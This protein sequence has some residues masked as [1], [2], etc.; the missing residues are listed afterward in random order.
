MSAELEGIRDSLKR[1]A[2]T[3]YRAF[4]TAENVFNTEVE[5][6]LVRN[7]LTNADLD[8]L[9]RAM[10]E[11]SDQLAA[12][13]WTAE[14]NR[15]LS[16]EQ[17]VENYLIL[18]RDGLKKSLE[19]FLDP[20]FLMRVRIDRAGQAPIQTTFDQ[21]RL[22]SYFEFRA[23]FMLKK[24]RA[25]AAGKSL[26]G[27]RDEFNTMA[28][29]TT[30][31]LDIPALRAS[32]E[33]FRRAPG[34]E[35]LQVTRE[36]YENLTAEQAGRLLVASG[37]AWPGFNQQKL[38]M[39]YDQ[40]NTL[41][42]DP[43]EYMTDDARI[44]TEE[45]T[46]NFLRRLQKTLARNPEANADLIVL[47]DRIITLNENKDLD[48]Q[49]EAAFSAWRDAEM[50]AL[51]DVSHQMSRR[52]LRDFLSSY[53]SNVDDQDPKKWVLRP[54]TIP[55]DNTPQAQALRAEI[56]QVVNDLK[57]DRLPT[58]RNNIAN[59]GYDYL[60]ANQRS[61]L[62]NRQHR[63]ADELSA[64]VAE[65]AKA[66]TTV[67]EKNQESSADQEKKLEKLA[68]QEL[69]DLAKSLWQLLFKGDKTTENQSKSGINERYEAV[70]VELKSRGVVDGIDW[71][72]RGT[73]L[74]DRRELFNAG[75]T[76]VSSAMT[77]NMDGL[78]DG[79]DGWYGAKVPATFDEGNILRALYGHDVSLDAGELAARRVRP[80]L[81][82]GDAEERER[83]KSIDQILPIVCEY[84][85]DFDPD[86]MVK[87][88]F[89]ATAHFNRGHIERFKQAVK[90]AWKQEEL[91]LGEDD[92]LTPLQEEAFGLAW[93]LQQLLDLR[94]Y[95]ALP[96]YIAGWSPQ[97][98][99]GGTISVTAKRLA[100]GKG[101]YVI[102]G[103]G[104]GFVSPTLSVAGFSDDVADALD[105]VS[106][107][108]N[109]AFSTEIAS[110]IWRDWHAHDIDS[111][112]GISEEA[113]VAFIRE[114]G[115]DA[116]VPGT[117]AFWGPRVRGQRLDPFLL[118]T[119]DGL[120]KSFKG[121][122]VTAPVYELN[123]K[124]YFEGGKA[125]E[126]FTDE[127][128][129]GF[130][131]TADMEKDVENITAVVAILAEKISPTKALG[132][133]NT[134]YLANELL[135]FS[136]ISL[137]HFGEKYHNKPNYFRYYARFLSNLRAG[138]SGAPTLE[139]TVPHQFLPNEFKTRFGFPLSRDRKI[140]VKDYVLALLPDVEKIWLG[141]YRVLVSDTIKIG[142][143]NIPRSIDA[144]TAEW[145][146][147][148]Y[149]F[150]HRRVKNNAEV[151]EH[152]RGDSDPWHEEIKKRKDSFLRQ[153]EVS[154]VL[155]NHFEV[156]QG[157]GESR[158]DEEEFYRAMTLPGL[159]AK[160]KQPKDDAESKH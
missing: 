54:E 16:N 151:L 89:H 124:G 39:L 13:L 149:Q 19:D 65:L 146:L 95:F 92:S 128:E 111:Q 62:N 125:S 154:P 86:T 82:S 42:S 44:Y 8:R 98:D 158:R 53:F 142:E 26:H 43:V 160:D 14:K 4:E 85:S 36:S 83:L 155:F 55:T 51:V 110:A 101:V 9:A 69:Y 7:E 47:V 34:G 23:K 11:M 90:Q 130:G 106:K 27:L 31:A 15:L 84:Y 153:G 63:F 116:V 46:L 114:R 152:L 64:R 45:Q 21:L 107:R 38:L 40:V 3:E 70:V 104:K 120:I 48:N 52:R 96:F 119:R 141:G 126:G 30:A 22:Y 123:L 94:T 131:V 78:Y 143:E 29:G 81:E 115:G 50:Q 87:G 88:E 138:I 108:N 79:G 37:T 99:I 57:N 159:S 118:R 49:V 157:P 134:R 18:F 145:L 150:D 66:A 71:A 93:E 5:S 147:F 60:D 132:T 32:H 25:N 144:Q 6:L 58:M 72:K 41:G 35:A 133:I 77:L 122:E 97:D 156:E 1:I 10:V 20:D 68:P 28:Y 103:K 75:I 129:A 61:V 12:M 135:M 148:S 24:L 76:G 100:K 137:L 136:R 17:D 74:T 56:I 140:A 139:I 105:S 80:T 127:C 109:Y 117:W 73:Y 121:S 112:P 91:G 102:C 2:Q 33:T 67:S 59:L 113:R